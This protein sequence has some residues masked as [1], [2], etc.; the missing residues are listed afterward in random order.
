MGVEIFRFSEALLQLAGEFLLL[1]V[2]G[3]RKLLWV[4]EI[5]VSSF[6]VDC[7]GCLE[8]SVS[9]GSGQ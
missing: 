4:L 8:T 3:F 6:L 7:L 2:W 1:I 9:S 5:V